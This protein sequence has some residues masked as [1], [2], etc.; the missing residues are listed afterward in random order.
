MQTTSHRPDLLT[1]SVEIVIDHRVTMG[2]YVARPAAGGPFP[3][4]IVAS[5]LFGVSAHVRDVCE[6]IAAMGFIVVAPDLNHRIAPG[7]EL[8]HD[9]EG[10]ERGFELL[11][12]LTRAEVLRDVR[13]AMDLLRDRGSA[14]VGMVGLSLGGHV[15]YLAA[16]E[17][18]LAAVAVLYGGWIPTTEIEI[19]RPKPTL[20]GTPAITARMLVLV[21]EDDHAIPPE[22]RHAIAAALRASGVRHELVEYPAAS[23]GFLCDRRGSF[24]PVAAQD[25]WRRIEAL[26]VTE[27]R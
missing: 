8:A 9:A 22:H 7:I 16:T 5:E 3:G 26:L 17:L 15:A 14:R 27:L 10:R 6:R 21:G 12:R 2:G 19:S 23:H 4:V 20:E 1:H 11:H 13:A 18:D 24:D 25:A